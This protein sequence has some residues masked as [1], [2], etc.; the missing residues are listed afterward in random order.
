MTDLYKEL[1]KVID[2]K[3]ILRDE[4]MSK[5]TS[6]KIGG[7][8]DFFIDIQN[9]KEL[10]FVLELANKNNIPLTVVGNGTNLLV[11]D[12]GI[13]GIV[14][15]I[16]ISDFKVVRKKDK[17]E[18]TIS[19]GYSVG[20]LAQLALKE[21]LTGLEFLA[22]IPGSIGGAIRMNAGA[23]GSQMQDIVI[24]TRYMERD[25]KIKKLNLDEHK[26]S[27]RNS[28]FAEMQDVIIL[29]TVIEA[30]YGDAKDIKLKM[31][32]YMKSRIEKQP[33]NLP[34]AGSTFKRNGDIITAKLIDECGLKGYRIGDAA[35]S[36][37]HAGFVVNVGNATAKEV[38]ELTNYIKDTVKKKKNIDIELEILKIG[39]I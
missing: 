20:K 16:S 3:Q 7:P 29:E 6:F 27:Y 12:K 26:F 8:A 9:V 10:K 39:E 33:L 31:D 17:A 38:L 25:G 30:K 14:I 24:S 21:E 5:H 19:S 1:Q 13:R 36:E 4:K 32:E 28:I 37:K 18:I 22:G 35:V 2:R 11:S 34:N 15:K 23:Y